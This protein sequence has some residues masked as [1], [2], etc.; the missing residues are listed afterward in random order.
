MCEDSKGANNFKVK[1]FL[2][3]FLR[4]EKKSDKVL[5]KLKI[6]ENNLIYIFQEM[7]L[8]NSKIFFDHFYSFNVSIQDH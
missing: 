1:Y 5:S 7:T 4:S 6:I 2:N 3:Y 8:L